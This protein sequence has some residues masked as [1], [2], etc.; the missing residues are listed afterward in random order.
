MKPLAW[1][2]V[3]LGLALPTLAAGRQPPIELAMDVTGNIT[4]N[5]DGSV[6][7]FSID[8][9]EQLSQGVQHLLQTT[10][11]GWTFDAI[12]A[13]GANA[14]TTARMTVHVTGTVTATTTTRVDGKDVPQNTVQIG[15]DRIDLQCPPPHTHLTYA[16]GCDPA[17]NVRQWPA[18]KPP[19]LPQYPLDAVKAQAEGA[20]HLLLDVDGLGRVMQMAVSR[21]DLYTHVPRAERI[22]KLLGDATLAAAQDWQFSVPTTGSAALAG[23]WVV[24]Q[25]VKFEIAGGHAA[26]V[27]Y[28]QWLASI[29]GPDQ[30]IP[31]AS[32]DAAGVIRLPDMLVTASLVHDPNALPGQ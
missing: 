28:G 15:V 27:G 5:A 23:H 3:V 17:A 4:V 7:G 24:E 19:A 30:V 16:R 32:A 20:V 8:H 11:P 21:V 26:S 13:A 31:W 14:A 1:L 10:L 2:L 18:D 25:T 29:P 6:K 22:R 12:K 9:P